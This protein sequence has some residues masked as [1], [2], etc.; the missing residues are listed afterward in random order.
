MPLVS[1]SNP[2][3]LSLLFFFSQQLSGLLPRQRKTSVCTL[4]TNRDPVHEFTPAASSS[5]SLQPFTSCP[6]STVATFP[7]CL[8]Q[9]HPWFSLAFLHIFH[10]ANAYC[11]PSLP[12]LI[13][14]SV[15][16][17]LSLGQVSSPV[18][19]D[20]EWHAAET[21]AAVLVGKSLCTDMEHQVHTAMSTASDCRGI[22]SRRLL[23]RGPA[24]PAASKRA[25]AR[26]KRTP[27]KLQMDD[28]GQRGVPPALVYS[29]HSGTLVCGTVNLCLISN[30]KSEI[31]QFNSRAYFHFTHPGCR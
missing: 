11:S 18:I 22:R 28:L 8:P 7:L 9:N 10:R 5:F 3:I 17:P 14:L 12:L 19:I 1:T 16:S 30:M 25:A 6:L 15:A 29:Q 23:K 24:T 31:F 21:I 2:F 27:V 13:Q 4:V 20:S 26:Y